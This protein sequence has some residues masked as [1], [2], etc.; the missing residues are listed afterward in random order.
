MS[1]QAPASSSGSIRPADGADRVA[2]LLRGWDSRAEPNL[3]ERLSAALIDLLDQGELEAGF[4][5]PSER[6]LAESLAVSRGTVTAAYGRLKAEGWLDS[7]VGSGS[8]VMSLKGRPAVDRTRVDGRL[9]TV[10]KDVAALDLTSGALPGLRLTAE[11]AL[12][13]IQERLPELLEG[14][15]YEPQG[16]PGLR[17]GV[18]GYYRALGAR[19]EPAEIAITTGSQQ[20]LQLLADAFIAPGDTVLVEDPTYRG[21]IEILRSR[22]AK[23]VPIPVTDDGPDPEALQQLVRRLDPRV[24]YLLPTA[25]NPTGH[26]VT[27]SRAKAIAA[28]LE[29]SNAIFVEDASPADLVLDRAT[30]PTPLGVDLPADRWVAIGSISKL[31]W[32]GL[33]IGWIRGADA[34]I[35]RITR[36]KTA[37][38]LGTSLV[39]QAIAVEC[40]KAVDQARAERREQLLQSLDEASQL[41]G[42]IAPEWSWRRPQGGSALWVRMPNTDTRALAELGRRHGV[43]LVPGAFFSAVDGFGD[44]MRIPFWAGAEALQAGLERLIEAWDTQRR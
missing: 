28:I 34:V 44:R 22:G 29:A 11:L 14:D 41:L 24:V 36:I 17:E 35:Q 12:P 8:R 37:T 5:L 23:L 6:R 39:S 10:S 3:P 43:S 32:G 19:T 16:M 38:D 7:R 25:H 18:A 30:P 1:S 2:R 13:V 27:A 21:A 40:L 15:G 20:A 31:F 42:E 4:R 9:S 33:R 26:V